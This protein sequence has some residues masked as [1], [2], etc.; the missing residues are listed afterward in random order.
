MADRIIKRIHFRIAVG[1]VI[2]MIALATWVLG[3]GGMGYVTVA[4]NLPSGGNVHIVAWTPEPRVVALELE[5]AGT[6]RVLVGKHEETA[7]HFNVKPHLGAVVRLFAKMKG[8]A[9]PDSHLRIVTDFVPAFVRY[10]G[11]MYSGPV[12]RVDLTAPAWK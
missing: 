11:P 1:G 2:L 8:Q 5:P 9:P 10:E 6:T 12:W 3:F 7:Q 4:K